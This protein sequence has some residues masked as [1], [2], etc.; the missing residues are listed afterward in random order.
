VRAAF[1]QLVESRH[2]DRPIEYRFRHRDGSWRILESIG[3]AV[4]D[5]SGAV[6]LRGQLA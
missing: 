2:M 4:V 1:V 3:K 5:P 6:V